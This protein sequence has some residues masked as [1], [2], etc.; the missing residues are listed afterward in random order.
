MCEENESFSYC[1][2]REKMIY[3]CPFLLLGSALYCER[4]LLYIGVGIY[5]ATD[6]GL[7][8]F[9]GLVMVMADALK[10][11]YRIVKIA[12]D[13]A[14]ILIGVVLGGKLGVTAAVYPVM[15]YLLVYAALFLF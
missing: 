14:M 12:F 2:V 13:F 8:P 11:E 7:D 4:I 15:K 10:K 5:I 3:T 6:M 9:T 1:A